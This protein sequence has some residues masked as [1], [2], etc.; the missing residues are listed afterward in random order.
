MIKSSNA[1]SIVYKALT[2]LVRTA[3]GTEQAGQPAQPAAEELTPNVKRVRQLLEQISQYSSSASALAPFQAS[4][5]SNDPSPFKDEKA[6]MWEQYQPVIEMVNTQSGEI[7]DQY[8]IIR[9]ILKHAEKFDRKGGIGPFLA[10]SGLAAVGRAIANLEAA[11]RGGSLGSRGD[12]NPEVR[13]DALKAALEMY[14]SA[15]QAK[16]SFPGHDAEEAVRAMDL[17]MKADPRWYGAFERSLAQWP[18]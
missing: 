8:M 7:K 5:Q 16:N 10:N 4:I 6:P 18:K 17:H 1:T 3:Q 2:P 12:K 11:Y 14:K 9:K 15:V 13:I